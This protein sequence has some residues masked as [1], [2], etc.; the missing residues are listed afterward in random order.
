MIG[1]STWGRIMQK[2]ALKNVLFSGRSIDVYINIVLKA[3]SKV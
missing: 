1:D 2:V 3:Y